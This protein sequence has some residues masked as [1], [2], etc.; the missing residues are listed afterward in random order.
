MALAQLTPFKVLIE[1][2]TPEDFEAL[3]EYEDRLAHADRLGLEVP[4]RPKAKEPEYKTKYY[5]LDN[6]ILDS[7]SADYDVQRD[8]PIII[9]IWY[10]PFTEALSIMNIQMKESEW[11]LLINQLGYTT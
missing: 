10:H 2:Y 3:Q 1:Q 9:A 4:E 11:K 5:N 6:Y 8:C 7:W